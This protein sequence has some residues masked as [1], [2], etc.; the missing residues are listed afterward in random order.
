MRQHFAKW[1]TIYCLLLLV[2]SVDTPNYMT[3]APKLRML[4]LSV[5]RRYYWQH[6]PSVVEPGGGIAD[7]RE[8]GVVESYKLKK[9]VVSS[10]SEAAEVCPLRSHVSYREC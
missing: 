7:M 5:C 3:E 10:A 6:D 8:L 1:A 2:F 9:A 4:E